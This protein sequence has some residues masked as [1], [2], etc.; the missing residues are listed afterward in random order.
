[1]IFTPWPSKPPPLSVCTPVIY[2][3]LNDRTH[4][5]V[6]KFN[7]TYSMYD[8]GR[9]N[10]FSWVIFLGGGEGKAKKGTLT[11]QEGLFST[12]YFASPGHCKVICKY[13]TF[14]NWTFR[15]EMG[16][17]SEVNKGVFKWG[18]WSKVKKGTQKK[19]YKDKGNKTL[20]KENGHWSHEKKAVLRRASYLIREWALIR[21][22]R[23]T[24]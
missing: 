18:T 19:N 6:F 16:H 4:M 23:G 24:R 11:C 3:T 9:Q 22:Q 10:V 15:K 14:I 5:I 13:L 20:N 8:Q 2:P 21:R 12:S 17:L 7:D 1:M